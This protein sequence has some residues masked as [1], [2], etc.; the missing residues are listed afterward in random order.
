M[1]I[2]VFEMTKDHV[3]V[4]KQIRWAN[5]ADMF[6]DAKMP[7][8]SEQINRDICEIIYGMPPMDEFDPLSDE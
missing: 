7:F 6:Y 4:V 1:S 3:N 2:R 5:V 8:G